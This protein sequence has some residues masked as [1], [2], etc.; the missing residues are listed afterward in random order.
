MKLRI[1]IYLILIYIVMILGA[2]FPEPASAGTYLSDSNLYPVPSISRPPLRSPMVDPVFGSTVTRLTDLSMVPDDPTV[3]TRG[4]RHEYSRYPALNAGNTLMAVLI[5]GGAS[6]GQHQVRNMATGALVRAIPRDGLDTEVS[7]HPTDPNLIFYRYANQVRFYHVDTGQA[8]T[9]MTFPEYGAIRTREE[10]RPSDNWR[11]FAFLGYPPG[12]WTKA[13]IVVA[14]LVDRKVVSRWTNV[15]PLPD[16][17]S[18]SP[19]GEYVVVQFVSSLGT[20]M[21]RRDDLSYIRTAFPDFSHSDFA[22]DA[23]GDDT[24]VYYAVSSAECADFAGKAGVASAR[25]R[26][27]KKTLLYEN[28]FWWGVHAS[29]MASRTHRGWV[30]ITSYTQPTTV[31]KPLMRELFWLKMDGSGEVR[32]IA[33][34]HSDVAIGTTDKDYWAE[35]HGTSSWDGSVAV[36]SSVWGVP[37]GPID[38]YKVT[39]SWFDASPP[40]PPPDTTPPAIP[41]GLRQK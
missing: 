21:Y 32:R 28:H 23:A 17:V 16:W 22:I 35:P 13:D 24:L 40:P 25:L 19:S 15:T 30:L 33:H 4:I 2:S 29:G 9:V 6:R 11:Y 39:G 38:F 20:R 26:D 1:D 12:D 36:F 34:H 27:G 18:M 7:W 3:P 8:E 10:G 41:T 37:Y 31:Q 14:D 5:L